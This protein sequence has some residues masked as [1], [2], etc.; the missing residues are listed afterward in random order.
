MSDKA[1]DADGDSAYP[2]KSSAF[3]TKVA[4]NENVFIMPDKVFDNYNQN[5]LRTDNIERSRLQG[6]PDP[7]PSAPVVDFPTGRLLRPGY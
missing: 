4:E 7:R 1:F 3:G 2:Q 6:K 5:L